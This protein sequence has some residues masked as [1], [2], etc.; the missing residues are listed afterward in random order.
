[1]QPLRG[2]GGDSDG[3][4]QAVELKGFNDFSGL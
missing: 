2:G 4:S 3:E 1:M